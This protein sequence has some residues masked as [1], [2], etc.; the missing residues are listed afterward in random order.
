MQQRGGRVKNPRQ[1]P[2]FLSDVS[3]LAPPLPSEVIALKMMQ[4][5]TGSLCETPN[6]NILHLDVSFSSQKEGS[7]CGLEGQ[8]QE[9]NQVVVDI[10]SLYIE[11]A[12]LCFPQMVRFK[13]R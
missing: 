7:F 9:C 3:F 12:F 2:H 4:M 11:K 10:H 13:P 6:C 8:N 1:F 5:W